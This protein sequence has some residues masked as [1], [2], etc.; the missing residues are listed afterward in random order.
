MVIVVSNGV[1]S[2]VCG[3]CN[4]WK[5][6]DDFY[7]DRTKGPSQGGKHCRCKSCHTAYHKAD[8]ARSREL[9]SKLGQRKDE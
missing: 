9:R 2:K 1:E 4:Q 5:P 7:A 8:Y 6:L 3:G